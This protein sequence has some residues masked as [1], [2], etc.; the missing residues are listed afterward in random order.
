[1]GAFIQVVQSQM[2]RGGSVIAV[3]HFLEKRPRPAIE[4]L[5]SS[6]PP[7]GFPAILLRIPLPRCCGSDSIDKHGAS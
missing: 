6:R 7:Q 2:A 5:V 4:F 1:M 3:Q